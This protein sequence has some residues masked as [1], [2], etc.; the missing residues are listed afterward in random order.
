MSRALE[1][2][3]TR[4]TGHL[5]SQPLRANSSTRRHRPDTY[6]SGKNVPLKPRVKWIGTLGFHEKGFIVWQRKSRAR[7]C[8][9]RTWSGTTARL[10]VSLGGPK[11]A[12]GRP[13]TASPCA[14]ASV[15]HCGA[16]GASGAR[17]YRSLTDY[18]TRLLEAVSVSSPPQATPEVETPRYPVGPGARLSESRSPAKHVP[19]PSPKR[20]VGPVAHPSGGRAWHRLAPPHT[21]CGLIPRA[22]G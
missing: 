4:A 8:R 13:R 10:Q 14:R 21:A 17:Q 22:R 12:F 1:A 18:L 11:G 7:E 5:R 15:C 16:G 9:P 3:G 6:A 2:C 20:G 19:T